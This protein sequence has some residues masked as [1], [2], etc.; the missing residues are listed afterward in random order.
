MT[1][2]AAHPALRARGF[3]LTELLA[4][5]TIIVILISVAVPAFVGMLRSTNAALA[6]SN[7]RIAIATARD[8]AVRSGAQTDSAA[9]FVYEPGGRTTIITCVAAGEMDGRTI[10]VPDPGTEP[11][12]LPAGW[13]V[14]GFA[15]AGT[16]TV[17]TAEPPLPYGWYEERD[18]EKRYDPMVDNWVFPE[19]GFY[20]TSNNQGRDTTPGDEGEY[21]QTFMVRFDGRTGGLALDDRTEGL[22]LL[23]DLGLGRSTTNSWRQSAQPWANPEFRL[24]GG[25]DPSAYVR[26]LLSRPWVPDDIPGPYKEKQREQLVGDISSDTALVRST[27]LLAL[28]DIAEMTRT[29]QEQGAPTGFRGVNRVTGCY[30]EP[31][32]AGANDPT[33]LFPYAEAV[34]RAIPAS[35]R[36]FTVDRYNGGVV[37]VT[38]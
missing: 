27:T 13:M 16:I 32:A 29:I 4:V 18:G 22:V 36:L 2:P 7:F 9:V 8:A 3:T 33:Y 20:R 38:P 12:A 31:P 17:P 24:E 30:Y 26:R 5:I 21:R 28:Y 25:I 10:W 34:N 11:I 19:T 35:A 14:S 23:P 37:E 1:N 15:P 6:Q